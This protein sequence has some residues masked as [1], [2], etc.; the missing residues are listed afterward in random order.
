MRKRGMDSRAMC[1]EKGCKMHTL[2]CKKGL[3]DHKTYSYK[4]DETY[5]HKPLPYK[6]I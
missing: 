5:D 1:A 6:Y 2:P 3:F 4:I